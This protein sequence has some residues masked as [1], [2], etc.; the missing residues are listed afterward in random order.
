MNNEETNYEKL[1]IT[2]NFIFCKVMQSNPDL[3]K[4]L[5]E[6]ITDRK[7]RHMVGLNGEKTIEVTPDGKGIRLDVYFEDDGSTMYDVEMQVESNRNLARRSRFYQNT[8]DSQALEKSSDY[9]KL[10]DSYVIFICPF[11]ILPKYGYHLYHF[12]PRADE[13]P[14]IILED[15]TSRIFVCANGKKDDVSDEM[16]AFLN[17][18]GG[19]LAQSPLTNKLDDA[20]KLARRNSKWRSEYMLS[21]V[22]IDVLKGEY[23]RTI[24]KK[25][26]LINEKD[27]VISEQSQALSEK[28]QA[29]SEMN[30]RIE[31]L[32]AIVA[33]LSGKIDQSHDD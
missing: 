5:V 1:T 6:L 20:V 7:I 28:D 18:L 17:Y 21:K 25:D 30:S 4:Q 26:A 3:C 22:D 31:E 8:I 27:T 19:K 33:N 9:I 10:L 24:A 14:S 2:N 32:E 23:E 12:R 15:G 16:K 29:L 13:D 11:N